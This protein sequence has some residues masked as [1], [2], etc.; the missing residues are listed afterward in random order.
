MPSLVWPPPI[1]EVNGNPLQYSCLENPRDRGAC[2]AA[3]YGV[4]QSR[5]R[6]KWLSSSSSSNLPWFMDLT[7]QMPMQYCS[8]QHQTYEHYCHTSTRISHGCT[9][10]PHPEPSSHLPPHPISQ[11]PPSALV[12]SALFHTSN[13]DWQSISHMVIYMFQCYS[14]KSSHPHLLPQSPKVCSLSLCLFCCLTY[15]VII[16]IFLNSIYMC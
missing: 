12:L 3:V 9:C 16:I 11:R 15:R 10:V 2:W 4:A 8:T 5:T 1:W 7:F 14:L 6:L 13:L